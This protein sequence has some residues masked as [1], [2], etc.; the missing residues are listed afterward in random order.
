MPIRGQRSLKLVDDGRS[1]HSVILDPATLELWVA[2]PTAAGRMRAFDL[3]HELR[4]EGDR[5]TPSADI[6]AEE[7]V[8]LD[9]VTTLRAALADLRSARAAMLV[10]DLARADEAAARARARVPTL[11]EA[12]ELEWTIA[13]ERGDSARARAS[14]QMWVDNGPDDSKAEE[15]ARSLIVR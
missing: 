6:P 7:N 14:A 3:R 5:P 12:L 13:N 4:G 2:D 8:E 15:R 1:V 11:P 9:R 10:D